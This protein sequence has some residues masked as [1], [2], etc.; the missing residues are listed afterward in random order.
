MSEA[1][2]EPDIV[3]ERRDDGIAVLTLN[4]PAR[5]N[6]LTREAVAALNTALDGLAADA[7]CRAVILTGAGRGRGFCSGQDLA[8]ANAR[9]GDQ[10]SGVIEKLFWQEQFAGMGK[11]LRTMPQLVI[12]AVNGPAVGAGMAIALSADVRI[13]TPTARFLVAAVRIGLSAGESGIS[14]LLPRM[15]GMSRAFDILL[16][17]RPIEAEESERIGLV[18]RLAKPDAL[19]AE[20]IGYARTVL[21]NSPYSVAHTKK[22]MW[23]NL[24]ASFDAAIG[25]ENRTQILATM[26]RD[27]AEATAAF[28]EKRPP[29]F[30]GR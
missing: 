11:R 16:T 22:L 30:E 14:Y 26:T 29:R 25:A 12:A 3:V 10:A 6:A 18:L 17:G 8:A 20:A 19:L 7:S 5:L 21:A 1:A 13:A 4:R 15:I 23:E 9:K 24:D 2:A 27:Y 28:V